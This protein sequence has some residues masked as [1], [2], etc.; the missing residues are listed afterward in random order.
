VAWLV[1]G[2][3]GS[4]RRFGLGEQVATEGE[5]GG[6]PA[7]GEETVLAD[8]VEAVGQGVQQKA[9]DELGGLEGHPLGPSRV[10]VAAP[11]EAD[12]AVGDTTSD[13]RRPV[14]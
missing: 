2:V 14:A 9:A 10:A 7:T 12:L 5:L 6:A 4:G 11:A 13:D 8:A 3:I 1:R